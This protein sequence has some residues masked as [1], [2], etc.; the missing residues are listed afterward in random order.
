MKRILKV[1]TAII[2]AG[3]LMLSSCKK[4]VQD[5]PLSS[6]MASR[7]RDGKPGH[8]Q[9]TKTFSSE[10]VVS[11]LNMQLAMFKIPLPPGTG[12][13]G[14]DRCQAYSGIALYEAVVPGMPAYKSLAG[15]L[16]DFPGMPSTEPGMAYHWGAS[17]NAALAEMS[18]RLFPTTAD[19]NKTAMNTLEND[20]NNVYAK[21]VDPATLQR[22]LAF[23]KEVATRVANWAAKDGSANVNDPYIPPVGP[24]LWIPT[25]PTPPIGAFAYQRR[26]IVP[27]SAAGTALVPLPPFSIHPASAFYAM[28]IFHL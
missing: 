17:A 19:G 20:W 14:T 27:G 6:E 12:S 15:Q 7:A 21:E 16:T 25:A 22:S 11:W 26:P 23:G 2:M 18:R 28:V 4:G 13:Q 5:D 8:L 1:F 10:V 24:G 9:Q 3:V